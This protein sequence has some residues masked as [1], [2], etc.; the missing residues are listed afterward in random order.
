MQPRSYAYSALAILTA[1]N[2]LNYIDRTVLYGVQPLIQAEFPRSDTDFGWLSGAFI[3][4]YMVAAPIAGWLA[5]RHERR[6]IIVAGAILWSGATL[7]TAVTYNWRTLFFR[8]MLVGV[9]EATFV[10]IAP[11]VISDLFDERVRGRMLAIFYLAIP[12]GSAMGYLL[13]GWLGPTHGWR[14]PFYVGATPGF[15][16]ALA[17]L[18]IPEPQRGAKDT[19]EGGTERGT[20]RGLFRNRGFWTVTFGMAMMTYA[21]GGLNVWMPT[22]LHRVRGVPLERADLIFGAIVAVDGLGATL[23]GGW[24]GDR[25]L[26]R[27]RTAYYLISAIG[28]ALAIP[29]MLV[30]IY[31]K[32][33]LIFPGICVGAFLLLVNTSPLNAALVNSVDA[34]IRATAVA[35]NIFVFHL[36]GDAFSPVLI[37]FIS[38][39][40]GFEVGFLSTVV[41]I[42]LSV[43]VLFYGMRFAPRV[44]IA[45]QPGPEPRGATA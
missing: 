43:I 18:F 24:L 6:L 3:L 21:L 35:V 14:Y 8:H 11:A 25:L 12:V 28:M 19:I 37:P 27:T 13:G 22:F 34:R 17:M 32:G 1:L 15:L 20:I 30:A 42:A 40:G 2:F 10:A 23:F 9:G 4:C 26:R 41:A 33:S 38:K 39:R 5:D 36:L 45:E 7:L 31:A 16:L 29:A 44:R